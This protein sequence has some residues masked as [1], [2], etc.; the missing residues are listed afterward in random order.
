M[1]GWPGER[2]ACRP[3]RGAGASDGHRTDPIFLRRT[4]LLLVRR[5]LAG[6]RFLLVWL[7]L[8]QRIRLGRRSGLAQLGSGPAG[9][10]SGQAGIPPR[11]P[12]K[13]PGRVASWWSRTRSGRTPG[14]RTSR[15]W[16]P[17]RRTSS[18]LDADITRAISKP[19]LVRGFFMETR[20]RKNV[21]SSHYTRRS[22]G[23]AGEDRV[24]KA[25]VR[26]SKGFGWL[27]PSFTVK[28]LRR[29]SAPLHQVSR[30]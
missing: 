28:D 21:C 6:T 12:R 24:A 13:A 22:K 10:R 4:K 11:R 29:S 25:P 8:A 7:R 23:R 9:I 1:C 16:P 26:T 15:R 5:R 27:N 17:G 3:L 14:R 18:S 2:D 19:R 20:D 30:Q